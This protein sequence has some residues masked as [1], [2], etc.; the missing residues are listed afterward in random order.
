MNLLKLVPI[1]TQPGEHMNR[2]VMNLPSNVRYYHLRDAQELALA[3]NA[4][5]C[6]AAVSLFSRNE[7]EDEMAIITLSRLWRAI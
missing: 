2:L 7:P 5:L 4:V 1:S 6:A 3:A